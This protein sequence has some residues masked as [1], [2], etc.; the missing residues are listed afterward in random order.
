MAG[1]HRLQNVALGN[2]RIAPLRGDGLVGTKRP[3]H[4]A[5]VKAR[6]NAARSAA[7]VDEVSRGAGNS[8]KIV[9]RD[10]EGKWRAVRIR[11]ANACWGAF[12]QR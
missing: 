9:S 3:S 11:G 2:E 10:V 4:S 12:V 6:R 1:T 5:M 7:P 8:S